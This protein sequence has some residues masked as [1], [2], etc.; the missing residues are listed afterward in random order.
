L[1]VAA[2][3]LL[4]LSSPTR[5][6]ET[7][8][9]NLGE[10]AA[11]IDVILPTTSERWE[12]RDHLPNLTIYFQLVSL[13]LWS[14]GLLRRSEKGRSVQQ[15]AFVVFPIKGKSEHGGWIIGWPRVPPTRI[16]MRPEKK[17]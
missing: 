14:F 1:R 16:L 2:G 9:G 8:H 10:I 11:L 6:T 12:F 15:R 13:L 5:G 17:R 3:D 7:D 4:V